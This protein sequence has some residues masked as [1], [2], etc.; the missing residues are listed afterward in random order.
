MRL[1]LPMAILSTAVLCFAWAA[2]GPCGAFFA[3][4]ALLIA[5]W[6]RLAPFTSFVGRLLWWSSFCSFLFACV[7]L[8]GW[9]IV[10]VKTSALRSARQNHLKNILVALE[11]YE[12]RN[13]SFPPAYIADASGK[14]SLSWRTLILPYLDE[15]AL[16]AQYDQRQPWNGP[17]NSKLA[18]AP[19]EF[20][21]PGSPEDSPFTSYA[22]VVGP[23]AAWRGGRPLK[24]S[25]FP[26]GGRHTI[27]LVET[28]N[29]GIPWLAPRDFTIEDA[30]VAIRSG[31]HRR[32]NGY[33]YENQPGYSMAAFAD[34]SVRPVDAF[35]RRGRWEN[36]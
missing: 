36:C 16:F 8:F 11:S 26:D 19:R 12:A 17:E 6:L 34:G 29:A 1:S 32:G 27:M 20:V 21:C 10:L 14:P 9:A 18:L 13:G 33:F 4:G 31:P 22:A 7:V 23:N 28:A 35:T 5:T 24:I 3:L 2:F 30:I 25:D 15:Q